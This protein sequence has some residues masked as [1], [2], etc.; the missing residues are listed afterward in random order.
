VS[1]KHI[2]LFGLGLE[3]G[4]H[5]VSDMLRHARLADDAGLD[6]FSASDHPDFAERLD[7]YAALGF[8]LGAT[9]TI[10]G[11]VICTNLLS[12]PAPMLARTVTGLSTISGGLCWLLAPKG[13]ADDGQRRVQT[14]TRHR[15]QH[16]HCVLR[17]EFLELTIEFSHAFLQ[18][19]NGC[20]QS[21]S[22]GLAGTPGTALPDS[23]RQSRPR[24]TCG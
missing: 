17:C 14:G 4:V 18:R 8:V 3:T 2:V 9:S 24:R 23:V 21:S 20:D 11:A 15:E 5:Q 16:R 13:V 10:S 22:F 6:V 12:R 7:A 19:L 1:P